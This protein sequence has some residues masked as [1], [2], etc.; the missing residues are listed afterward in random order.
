[1]PT[2]KM[3]MASKEQSFQLSDEAELSLSTKGNLSGSCSKNKHSHQLSST[4]SQ[5]SLGEV[6]SCS[7]QMFNQTVKRE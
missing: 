5:L 2:A 4:S 3:L 7:P 1:M 6:D